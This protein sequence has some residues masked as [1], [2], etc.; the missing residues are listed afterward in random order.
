MPETIR[1]AYKQHFVSAS[2]TYDMYVIF[3]ELGITLLTNNGILSYITPSKYLSAEYATAL[4]NYILT[5][6]SLNAISDFSDVRVFKSAGVS[7]LI[8][9]LSKTPQKE[10]VIFKTYKTLSDIASEH[11]Y[12]HKILTLLPNNL[13]GPMLSNKIDIFLKIYRKSD[14]IENHAEVN[15]CSTAA[16]AEYFEGNLIENTPKDA[17]KFINNGTINRYVQLWGHKVIRTNRMLYPYLQYQYVNARRKE[18]FS[19]EKL[20]FVKLAKYPQIYLDEAG[21][22]ASAN[23]NMVYNLKNYNYK[24]LL[25]FLNSKLFNFAYHTMFGG[26]AM[27]GTVQIQAPQIKKSL[28]PQLHI[29]SNNEQPIIDLVN[30]I[31]VVKES[32]PQADTSS[33]EK[34]IDNLIYQLYELT[35]DEIA[36]IEQAN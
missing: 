14:I 27:L 12:D 4:R 11:T 13:W 36:M 18:M 10:K 1:K 17:F 35:P 19:K 9:L 28:I 25:G 33:L 23:T 16:E 8:S 6:C 2:G 3:F 29:I 31:L 21:E 22:F 15:A 26:L 30:Q 20:I 32:D 5:Y 24:F 7:T 34:A